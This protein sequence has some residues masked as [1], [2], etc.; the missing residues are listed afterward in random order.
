MMQRMTVHTRDYNCIFHNFQSR[1]TVTV[2]TVKAWNQS[3]PA[4]MRLGRL[5][6]DCGL[7]VGA[8]RRLGEHSGLQDRAATLTA[9]VIPVTQ[10]ELR[11]AP[12]LPGCGH[13][14]HDVTQ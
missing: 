10:S 8:A 3:Q 5:A 2:T 14:T 1:D 7:R 11:K 12:R 13:C 4:H 9:T 6:A